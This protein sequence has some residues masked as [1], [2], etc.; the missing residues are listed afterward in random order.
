MSAEA[1]LIDL[2]IVLPGPFPPHQPLEGVVVHGGVARTSGALPRD[3]E[4]QLPATGLC[5]RDVPTALGAECAGL[6][7]LNALSLLR[8]EVGSLDAVERILS[9]TVFVACTGDFI[10]QPAVADGA[11]KVLVDVFGDAGRHTRSAIGVAALPRGAC[12]EVE[13]TAALR[14][15]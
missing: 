2:G 13:L 11:S 14:D 1:R 6:A 12:V 4:G 15:R 9:I 3:G 7:T 8:A 5:G 10:E